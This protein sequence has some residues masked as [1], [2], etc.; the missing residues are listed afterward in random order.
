MPRPRDWS[1]S[2]ARD[3]FA[4]FTGGLAAAAVLWLAYHAVT[5]LI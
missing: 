2:L 3:L 5:W 1:H 4:G